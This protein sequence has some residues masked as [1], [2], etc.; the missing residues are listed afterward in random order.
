MARQKNLLVE[1]IFDQLHNEL[2]G[3]VHTTK[4]NVSEQKGDDIIYKIGNIQ[5]GKLSLNV[6]QHVSLL[7]E[8]L[9]REA[10]S[11]SRDSTDVAVWLGYDRT[12]VTKLMKNYNIEALLPPGRPKL[13]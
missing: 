4:L 12:T 13:L 9:F 8:F 7:K 3:N 5:D 10:L 2:N 6:K 1:K 11:R